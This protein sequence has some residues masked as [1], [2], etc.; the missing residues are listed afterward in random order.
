MSL[1]RLLVF[2]FSD[3]VSHKID[4]IG[5]YRPDVSGQ[6]ATGNGKYTSE[7]CKTLLAMNLINQW[8][9]LC[10]ALL[11]PPRSLGSLWNAPS[12]GMPE[13]NPR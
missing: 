9:H 8:C 5:L 12:C 10:R 2:Y 11:T 1:R 13:T 4:T 3:A 6:R 7:D